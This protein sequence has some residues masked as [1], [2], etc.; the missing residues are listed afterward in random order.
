MNKH[1]AVVNAILGHVL[2]F[3]GRYT[4]AYFH[5]MKY[6]MIIFRVIFDLKVVFFQFESSDYQVIFHHFQKVFI[7]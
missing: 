2:S 4:G 3:L 7:F 1:F 6:E 5:P